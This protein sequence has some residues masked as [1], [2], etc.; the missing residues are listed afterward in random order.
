MQQFWVDDDDLSPEAAPPEAERL[1]AALEALA[2]RDQVLADRTRRLAVLEQAA[3]RW[4]S[5][6][7]RLEQVYQGAVAA[8]AVSAAGA[9]AGRG[10]PAR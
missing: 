2:A 1:R 7:A 8:R 4:T 5:L 3:S 9:R 10:G 6:A